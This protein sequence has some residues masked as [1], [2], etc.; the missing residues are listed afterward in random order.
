MG[1]VKVLA[2]PIE[3]IAW[4]DFK[5]LIHPL[6]FRLIDEDGKYKTIAIKNIQARKKEKLAGNLMQVFLCRGVINNQEIL[7]EIKYEKDTDQWI[8]FKM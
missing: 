5:G 6:R 2:K 4:F 3:M 1:F 8:L 7:F